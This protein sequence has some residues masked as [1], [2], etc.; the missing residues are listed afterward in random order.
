[1]VYYDFIR[2]IN[3][4]LICFQVIYRS[5]HTTMTTMAMTVRTAHFCWVGAGGSR[6]TVRKPVRRLRG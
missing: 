1:M 5:Q 4:L 6:I 3:S 2:A